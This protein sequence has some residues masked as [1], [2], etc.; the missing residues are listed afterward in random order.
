MSAVRSERAR[1]ERSDVHERCSLDD[2]ARRSPMHPLAFRQFLDTCAKTHLTCTRVGV[3]TCETS[4]GANLAGQSC[5]RACVALAVAL[6][7]I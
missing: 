7:S 2:A 4:R 3:G 1:V 6:E 5:M